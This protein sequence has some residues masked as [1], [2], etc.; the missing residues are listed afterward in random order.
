MASREERVPSPDALEVAIRIAG[1][2]VKLSTRQG[3]A[4]AA[5]APPAQVERESDPIRIYLREVGSTKL[6]EREGEVAIAKRIEQGEA[7]VYQAL[8]EKPV[9]IEKLLKTF[10]PE[11]SKSIAQIIQTPETRTV[12]AADERTREVLG[13]FRKI[14]ALG[15]EINKARLVL[16]TLRRGKRTMRLEAS[17]DRKVAEVTRLIKK[18]GFTALVF[19]RLVGCL[20]EIERQLLALAS[21]MRHQTAAL[22]EES[23]PPA[24]REIVKGRL[25]A[26]RRTF[27]GLERQFGVS[28]PGIQKTL[29]RIRAGMAAAEQSK[30]ELILA[31]LR[32]VISIA[33]K[34]MSRGLQLLELIQE[35]NIGLMR[36]VEKFDYRLGYKFSTYATWW[37]RQAVTRAISDQARTVR[38]PVHMVESIGKL[39]RVSA[40]LVQELGREPTAEEIA[41][42]LGLPT[43]K[44]RYIMKVAQRPISLNSPVGE[45]EDA[46]FGDFIADSKAVSPDDT[47][48]SSHLRQKTRGILKTLTPREE[49]ILRMRF[50]IDDGTEHTLEEVGRAFNVTRERIRQIE[51]KALKR[52]RHPSRA[53]H[54]RACFEAI[55]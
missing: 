52:L 48:M 37:I 43:A 31:N 20:T 45:D 8:A 32:L 2:R 54:L 13:C 22:D 11:G 41:R 15:C 46:R 10:E 51:S 27:R 55:R 7:R 21:A 26:S 6:L 24:Q 16:P 40:T 25:A 29:R 53:D 38:V 14:A 17:I 9:T 4:E 42:E 50:G 1:R 35:G 28:L 30:Q 3:S 19:D 12:E 47:I 36:G 44:A 33:K 39:T 49:H 5:Q 34:Y 23:L 18:I